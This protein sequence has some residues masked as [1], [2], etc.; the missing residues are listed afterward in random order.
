MVLTSPSAS[1]WDAWE[2]EGR[3]RPAL[4]PV[5]DAELNHFIA[6]VPDRHGRSA[7]DVGCGSGGFARQLHRFGFDVT[8]LDFSAAA[9]AAARLTPLTDVRYLHHDLNAGD[10]PG[11]PARAMDLVVCR[12]VLPFLHHPAAWMRRVRDPWLRPGGQMYLAVPVVDEH[13]VQPGGMTEGE[14]TALPTGW[15]D[16]IRF[17]LRGPVTCLILRSPAA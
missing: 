4:G 10:P 6:H 3:P 5:T 9:L 1:V 12:H 8:G 13:A 14:I 11:L 17:E 15:A 7:V 16:V 2:R